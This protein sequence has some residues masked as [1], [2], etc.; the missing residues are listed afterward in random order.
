MKHVLLYFLRE[1]EDAGQQ[2]LVRI[3]AEML[4]KAAYELR[5]VD[6]VLQLLQ[7]RICVVLRLKTLVNLLRQ[8]HFFCHKDRHI[9]VQKLQRLHPR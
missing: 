6:A 9:K 3:A 8:L 5:P 4:A 7:Q 1:L 2:A